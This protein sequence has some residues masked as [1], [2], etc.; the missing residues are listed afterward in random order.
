MI[1]K[2]LLPPSERPNLSDH[3]LKPDQSLAP[4]VHIDPNVPTAEQ[5]HNPPVAEGMGDIRMTTPY[6]TVNDL[7]DDWLEC[8]T[9]AAKNGKGLTSWL[10][11]LN[12]TRAA[13]ETIMATCPEFAE[14]VERCYILCAEWWEDRGRDLTCG[15]LKGGSGYVWM[16]NMV[17]RFGWTSSKNENNSTNLNATAIVNPKKE[18]TEEEINAELKKRGI[19]L[20]LLK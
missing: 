14:A 7:R 15:E 8:M 19:P 13:F 18:L 11:V 12:I 2:K 10:R 16:A 4:I 6:L 3:S 5:L 9:S 17:N 1:H 20:D